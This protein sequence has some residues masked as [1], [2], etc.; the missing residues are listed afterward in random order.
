VSTAR[1]SLRADW[2][3][4]SAIGR[5]SAW[6]VA[7]ADFITALMAVFL[8][9]WLV[10]QN[11]SVRSAV[12]GYFRSP[13][14]G[15]PSVLSGSGLAPSLSLA[16]TRASLERA[17]SRIREATAQGPAFKELR[18]QVDVQVTPEGLRIELVDSARVGFFD[19]GSATLRPDAERVLVSIGRE[20]GKLEHGVVIEGHTDRRGYND[21]VYGNWEL[22]ADRANAARRVMQGAGLQAGQVTAVRGFA[23]TRLRVPVD[24]YDPQN[25]RVSVVVPILPEG[26]AR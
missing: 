4:P 19:S 6:K 7:Y 3:A 8:V 26:S 16:Q 21:Q 24:P 9:M 22:S 10:T 23:D 12:A 14:S 18:D 2:R 25:R 20:L 17:A 13:S 5:S 11:Q 1:P 15:G